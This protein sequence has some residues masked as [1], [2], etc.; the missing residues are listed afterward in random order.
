MYL[1]TLL[2]HHLKEECLEALANHPDLQEEER[3]SRAIRL[4]TE[5]LQGATLTNPTLRRPP[6]SSTTLIPD[7]E[8]CEA[9]TWASHTGERCTRRACEGY[10]RIHQKMLEEKG[11]LVFGRYDEE[12]PVFNEKGNRIPWYDESPWDA[13]DII[14]QYQQMELASFISR[15]G[16]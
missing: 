6:A 14:L 7:E 4:L 3:Y 11:Y 13:I 9:R 15:E 8:R 2:M 12:R 1:Q 5:K 16:G 10:C